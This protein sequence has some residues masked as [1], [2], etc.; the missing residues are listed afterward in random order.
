MSSRPHSF[1]VW[2]PCQWPGQRTVFSAEFLEGGP[3]EEKTRHPRRYGAVQ[4]LVLA[5]LVEAELLE[6]GR[7]ID[8]DD[9]GRS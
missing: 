3:G 9:L 7:G 5:Q 1:R 8:L 6:V 2:T 4:L